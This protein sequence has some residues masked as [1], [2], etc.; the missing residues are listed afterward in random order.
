M[1]THGGGG[2]GGGKAATSAQAAALA[3]PA[4]YLERLKRRL[5]EKSLFRGEVTLSSGKKSNYYLDCRLTTLDP[6]GSVL[7]A[8]AILEWLAAKGIR[9]DGI[10]GMSIGADPVVASVV[11]L[12]YLEGRPLP[13]FLVRKERKEHGMQKK[14]EGLD[15]AL[16]NTSRQ[17]VIVDD[18]CTTG[19]STVE[20]IEAAEAEGMN[21]VAVI[22]VV[23]REEGGSEILRKKYAY[24][25]ISTA[26]ELLAG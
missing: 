16:K 12:S 24:Y 23:D 21:V 3:I 19:K 5:R 17:V 8:H 10:G 4:N 2:S 14:I 1:A 9:A 13:G 15:A 26:R 6:E 20:A 25:A 11:A 7:V 22:S 18:V